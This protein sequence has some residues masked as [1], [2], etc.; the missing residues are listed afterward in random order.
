MMSGN[1]ERQGSGFACLGDQS[2]DHGMVDRAH[3]CIGV[4]ADSPLERGQILPGIVPQTGDAAPPWRKTAGKLLGARGRAS[5]MILELMP[6]RH[7]L[8]GEAMGVV[9]RH[10]L[11][12]LHAGCNRRNQNRL[13]RR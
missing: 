5:K 8:I 12:L 10:K 7:R 6:V 11:L 1:R 9:N 4:R 13:P 3:V 2:S